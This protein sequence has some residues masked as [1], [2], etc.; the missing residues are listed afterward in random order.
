MTGYYKCDII[1]TSK[2]RE[3]NKMEKKVM[4]LCFDGC[5]FDGVVKKIIPLED[6][7]KNFNTHEYEW[8]EVLPNSVKMIK[9]TATIYNDERVYRAKKEVAMPI[10]VEMELF[11]EN[12]FM[13]L[14]ITDW[15]HD[16]A[17]NTIAKK[18][19]KL[20]D[21]FAIDNGFAGIFRD[22]W[23]YQEELVNE[24]EDYII[25]VWVCN[26]EDYAGN[27]KKLFNQWTEYFDKNWRV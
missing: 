6:A 26:L 8:Y 27:K 3:V 11:E 12:G 25:N 16:A 5:S 14:D 17:F 2:E 7:I 15:S 1:D 20:W 21:N 4:I 9:S 13:Q 18:I 10:K 23:V 22:C 19:R 24:D